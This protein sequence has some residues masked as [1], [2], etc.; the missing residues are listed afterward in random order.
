M[1]SAH[2]KII[3]YLFYKDKC[4]SFQWYFILK[5]KDNQKKTFKKIIK[6]K[7]KE[8]KKKLKNKNKERHYYKKTK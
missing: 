3:E 4:Q 6:E 2:I 1:W 8:I 7:T 5:K